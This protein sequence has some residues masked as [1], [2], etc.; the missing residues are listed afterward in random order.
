[1]RDRMSVVLRVSCLVL[2]GVIVF[3]VAS[4]LAHKDPLA[5]LR[6]TSP[7]AA[8]PAPSKPS[9]VSGQPGSGQSASNQSAIPT[10][11]AI[12][13]TATN[14]TNI[15]V[16]TNAATKSTNAAVRSASNASRRV[17]GVSARPADLPPAVQARVDRVVQS[18]I[19]GAIPRPLPM[20]LLGIA[21]KDAFIRTPSGQ[22]G[23]MREGEELGGVKLLRI[24]NNRVLVEHEEQK[25]ELTVFSGLGGEALLPKGE[26][27]PQ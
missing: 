7:A 3:Q 13:T 24:G 5:D 18:E 11:A 16:T 10:N 14:G 12:A 22:V 15:V 4:L 25:K 6:I 2:A 23:L 21:G 27:S 1:M 17:A 19:F 20:A 9:E 26:R 8:E